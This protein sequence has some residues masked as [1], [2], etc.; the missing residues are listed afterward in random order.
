MTRPHPHQA[1][2]TDLDRWAD[3]ISARSDLPRLVRRLIRAE[4]DQVQR[5]DMRAGE[6]VGL[7]GYD[8]YVEVE[9]GRSTSFVPEGLSIWEMGVGV[10]PAKKAQDDWRSRK[11]DPRGAVPAEMTFVFVT[12]RRWE[13]KKDWEQRR[14]KERLW[15]DVRV[16]DA[17]DI[18]QALEV[19]P[20][21]RV[22]LS[23][24]LGMDPHGA[25]TIE[26]WWGRYSRSFN[27]TLTASVVLAGRAD[28]AGS[29]ARRMS[30]DVGRTFV[31]AASMDDGLAF[32]ACSMMTGPPEESEPILARSLLVHDGSMMRRL[33]RTSKLLILLPYDEDLHRDAHLVESH[34]VVFVVT[35][36]GGDVDIE[37]P[38][39]DHQLL[40]EALAETGVPADQLDRHVRAGTKSLKAL[41]RVASK[42]GQRDPKEWTSAFADRAV[43]RA[44][45][46][47]GWN[48]S[49]SGDEEVLATL[50]DASP[51]LLNET[52]LALA[53]Q[54]DPLFTKV[55]STWAVASTSDSWRAARALVTDGDLDA[56]ERTA[57][58]VLGAVDPRLELPSEERW[59]ASVHGKSPVHSS[60]LR[61]GL[62]RTM[63]LLGS[64]GDE[65][66][67][68]GGRSGR[69]WAERVTWNLLERANADETAQLWTSISDVLPL[70]AEAAPDAFL[71]AVSVA[72]IGSDP[73]VKK[74]F[75]DTDD[76]WNSSSPHTGLLWALETVAW[77]EVHFGFA[78]EVLASLEE[79]DPGGRLSNRPSASLLSLFRAWL[80]QTSSPLS[81]RIQT[82]DALVRRHPDVGWRLVL[83][84]F[85]N[86]SDF[87]LQGPKPEFRDW[88]SGASGVTRADLNTTL[89]AAASHVLELAAQTATRW[90]EVVPMFERLPPEFQ[91]DVVEALLALTPSQL[92]SANGTA[93]WEAL[94][95]YVRRHR[96]HGEA[97]GALPEELLARLD[98]VVE[99]L[100]PAEPEDANRWLFDDW[101]PAIGIPADDLQVYDAALDGRRREAI[102]EVLASDGL[103]GVYRLASSVELP[104]AVGSALAAATDSV[105]EAVTSDLDNEINSIAQFANGF[106]RRRVG[107]SLD[108][109][110]SWASRFNGRPLIQARLFQFVENAPEA[111]DAMEAFDEAVRTAY[112]SEFSPFGRG[113]DFPLINEAVTRLLQHGRSAI[114]VH[115]LTMYARQ[116]PDTV[117]VELVF[118]ALAAFSSSND[119]EA[120]TVSP[121]DITN[122]LAFLRERDVDDGRIALLE[123]RY[124][125]MLG[126]DGHAPALERLLASD[127]ASFV[128]MIEMVF[129][130]ANSNDE[131]EET[132]SP[133][134]VSIASNA[135]RLLRR[136]SIVPGTRDDGVVDESSLRSWLDEARRLLAASDRLDIG[137]LQ[138]GEVLAHSPEDP[139]GTFPTLPVRNVMEDAPDDRLAR[140]FGIGVYNM[141][142]VT[143]RGMTDGGQ[144]EY[145]LAGKY[146]KWAERAQAT[147]PRT[148]AALR[149]IAESFRADGRRNDEEARRR[150]EGMDR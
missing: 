109:A 30:D 120:S 95:S 22:W 19:A 31:R 70:L 33:E 91:E 143:S 93:L 110:R 121:Y 21:V 62:A 49:R 114:S 2:G 133:E 125:P 132:K 27:P 108:R 141:R 69:E 66:R 35:D 60:N 65:I 28:E 77:S 137:E 25:T 11:N 45:L 68:V 59:A 135:F 1:D 126:Y 140:G 144:Q 124:L 53:R 104:W 105:D 46:A 61:R 38:P 51:E 131:T 3:T 106:S 63:A 99:R 75:Q 83:D 72:S 5:A 80:P 23:E 73:L 90:I 101:H 54:A 13:D 71:R 84:M 116:M 119:P 15:R 88:A 74:L 29:L 115:A 18:E 79:I 142:G 43:R 82:L 100:Q 52:L 129:K 34:H 123:W 8:G 24:L 67:L 4:N 96:E 97:P 7:S 57:Q 89:V 78:A 102:A 128:Q 32:A 39:L 58:T 81:T 26:D 94:N 14:R 148:A 136:W 92:P 145:D 85:P 111:W 12:P 20:A 6:G 44:W 10:D 130:P 138:I 47:G 103:A 112:W 118:E 87:A 48:Q 107:G 86:G 146:A 134:A 9:A 122:L 55:G 50:C 36:A 42:R 117:D 150:M 56:L 147:H 139:D 64:R 17:D 113:T 41:Q 16:L 149:D 98:L 37:L 127:A 76:R 40:R